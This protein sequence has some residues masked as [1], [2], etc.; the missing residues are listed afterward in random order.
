MATLRSLN[1]NIRAGVASL[2]SDFQKANS[3]VGKFQQQASNEFK[4][5]AGS[6]FSVKGAIV[7]LVGSAGLGALIKS[8]FTNIDALAKS[9]DKLGITTQ[10]MA[11]LQHAAGLAG[12]NNEKL[13]VSLV[14][15]VKN[16]GD[17]EQ[18]IGRAQSSFKQLDIT[19]D[20]LKGLKAD[21]Q[22]KLIADRLNMVKDATERANIA[23]KVFGETGVDILNITSDG[24]KGIEEATAEAEKLGIALNRIDS[25][26]I[27]MANDAFTRAK[28]AISGIGNRIAVAL[29]PYLKA[30]ADWFTELVKRNNGF[31]DAILQGFEY[32]SRAVGFFAD[33]LRGL[34][35]VFK[36]VEVVGLGF[37]AGIL[38][39]FDELNKG[40]A[41]VINSLLDTIKGPI[42]AI[43]EKLGGVS[44]KAKQLAES[45]KGLNITPAPALSNWADN[46]RESLIKAEAELLSLV[47]Q[48]MP[49]KNVE[50][51][52]AKIKE[53]SD[54]AAKAIADSKTAPANLDM[55]L[56]FDKA[57]YDNLVKSL[58]TQE[59]ALADSYSRRAQIVGDALQ[60]RVIDE[61]DAQKTLL[62]LDRKY[63]ADRVQAEVQADSAVRNSRNLA[64]SNAAQLLSALGS[65]SKIAAIASLAIQKALAISET[66]INTQVAAVRALAELGPV[67][68][69]A[70]AASIESWG[71]AA[72]A[73]IGATGLIEARNISS[74]QKFA[75]GGIVNGATT[76]MAGEAGP[77]AIVPLP[78][79]RSIP[80]KFKSNQSA[81]DS[82]SINITINASAIDARGIDQVLASRSKTIGL[83]VQSEYR[84]MSRTGGPYR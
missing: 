23:Y 81:N 27:E 47:N 74:P 71:S 11:G 18:G 21:E 58:Y 42:V 38:T 34:H 49:S 79:G 32:A 43:L 26:K 20:Q 9:A 35:V 3:L 51:W 57:S 6:I 7:G 52:F 65:K 77:E 44:D 8:S 76:F 15:M 69:P 62:A 72:I 39:A 14:T 80:V 84:R 5:L 31:K 70:A 33:M 13:N 24:S 73:L 46:A 12:I 68:G 61:D 37:V 30:A 17:M 4:K 82:A 1:I 75:T 2:A 28:E 63:T 59:E 10:A 16:I 56:G 40:G 50:A 48:P 29:S 54:K 55:S 60:A 66:I 36:G 45:L 53:S 41:A 64:F 83:I 19:A 67:A 78:D 25:A 22:F